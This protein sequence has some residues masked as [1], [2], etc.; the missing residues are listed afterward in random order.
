MVEIQQ[1]YRVMFENMAQGA[2][3][4][5]ADGT[6]VDVNPAALHMFGLSRDQFLGVV[7]PVIRAGASSRR[8]VL[9]SLRSSTHPWSPC[10]A[11]SR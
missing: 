11:G 4:Q 9:T 7:H 8:M 5:L 1:Q 2:F 6:L 3:Y 10:A